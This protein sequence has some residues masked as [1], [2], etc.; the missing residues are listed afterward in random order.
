MRKDVPREPAAPFDLADA[1]AKACYC[2]CHRIP[3][4]HQG[5]DLALPRF[6]PRPRATHFIALGLFRPTPGFGR[7]FLLNPLSSE[8]LY[9]GPSG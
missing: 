1:V 6:R 2:P 9:L 4:H 3:L 5:V 7:S 8:A